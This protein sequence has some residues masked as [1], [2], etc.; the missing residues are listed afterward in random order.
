M[1]Y[2]KRFNE[3]LDDDFNQFVKDKS[4]DTYNTGYQV[5]KFVKALKD[6]KEKTEFKYRLT[7]GEDAIDLIEEFVDKVKISDSEQFN[8]RALVMH[9]RLEEIESKYNEGDLKA[10]KE[11]IGLVTSNGLNA[12]MKYLTEQM[13]SNK[14]I[15]PERVIELVQVAIDCLE[16]N[17]ELLNWTYQR[18]AWNPNAKSVNAGKELIEELKKLENN[19]LY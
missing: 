14:V 4:G 6:P 12:V 18:T 16:E 11:L 1:K 13:K 7:D 3:G 9:K 10:G 8:F 15:T 17:N 2:L 19:E 5:T